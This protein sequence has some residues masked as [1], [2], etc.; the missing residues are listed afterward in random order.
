[1][2]SDPMGGASRIPPEQRLNVF[3]LVMYIPGPLG[4]FLDDLR[5]ELAPGCNP[6][7]HVSVLP[8]RSLAGGWEAASAQARHLTENWPVFDVELT[9]IQIFPVTDVI[10]IEVGGGTDQLRRMHAAMSTGPLEFP[11][12]FPYHPHITLAQELP[13]E[14]VA[15]TETLARRR[16]DEFQGERKFKAAHA[17]FV[18]NSLGD[19]WVDLAEYS[20]KVR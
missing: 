8:P 14:Q 7:A 4:V 2:H 20:L 18:Q 15:A 16:W 10:Y 3:A 6:H 12:P 9:G 5:R 11:E 1:M 13:H 17:T 19:R